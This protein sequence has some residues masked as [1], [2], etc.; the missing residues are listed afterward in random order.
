MLA[1]YHS[2]PYCWPLA[3]GRLR[4]TADAWPPHGGRLPA[5]CEVLIANDWQPSA[6]H[7][8]LVSNDWPPTNG[9]LQTR[10]MAPTTSAAGVSLAKSSSAGP[11]HQLL[12]IVA[13]AGKPT[14][15]K[16]SAGSLLGRDFAAPDG[17]PLQRFLLR[18]STMEMAPQMSGEHAPSRLPLATCTDRPHPSETPWGRATL[19]RRGTGGSAS[20]RQTPSTPLG[21]VCRGGG[22]LDRRARLR[23][24]LGGCPCGS[25]CVFTGSWKA[26]MK[27]LVTQSATHGWQQTCSC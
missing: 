5:G 26:P 20:G 21:S 9:R 18:N 3:S 10:M 4:L 16:R 23:T 7:L 24:R 2:P 13:H 6:G 27:R 17:C 15:S 25:I 12:S 1:A 11:F 8:R 22:G 14:T 19:P